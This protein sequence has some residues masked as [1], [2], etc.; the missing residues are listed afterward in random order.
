MYT[1]IA[2]LRHLYMT[3]RA[4]LWFIPGTMVISAILIAF[5]LIEVELLADYS[6]ADRWPRIFGAGAEGS[7]AMLST[8]ASSMITVAGVAFSITIV[9]LALVSE[10]YTSRVLR[11]FMSDRANQ[12]VLGLFVSVFVYC[13]VVMR[14]IRGGDEGAFVP[15]IAVLFGLGLAVVGIFYLIYFIH[16]M[17]QSI[18]VAHVLANIAEETRRSIDRVFPDCAGTPCEVHRPPTIPE[19]WAWFP[20]RAARTGYVEFIEMDPLFSHAQKH[21]AIAR[22]NVRPGDFIVEGSPW[23]HLAAPD[24]PEPEQCDLLCRLIAIGL[25]RTIEQDPSFGI[26]QMVDIALRALSPGVNDTT[27]AITSLDYITALLTELLSRSETGAYRAHD[28]KI[29][30]ILRMLDFDWMIR[31]AYA[32]IRQ[33]A[34]GNVAVLH[35]LLDSIAALEQ[36]TAAAHLRESLALHST[37]IQAVAKETIPD[38]PERTELIEK[39]NRIRTALTQPTA[40]P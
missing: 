4:S 25:Q 39:A 11:N 2:T 5:F 15:S 33:N 6:L 38:E 40:N 19:G 29:H 27:T 31:E 10:Q 28:G 32:Q 8:I 9:A 35:R 20:V 22:M 26:R 34:G 18:Q 14:T 17:S 36:A 24:E 7:R 12:T 16:H 1:L 13:L 37:A 23:L 3:L 30:I 21:D